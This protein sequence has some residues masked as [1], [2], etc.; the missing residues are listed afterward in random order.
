MIFN[1]HWCSGDCYDRFLV[2]LKEMRESC[3]IIEQ[4]CNKITEGPVWVSCKI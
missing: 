3:K 2:R 4:A 1:G